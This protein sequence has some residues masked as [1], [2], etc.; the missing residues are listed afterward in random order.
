MT[1]SRFYAG[2]EWGYFRPGVRK[3]SI[4]E[5]RAS[6][7]NSD[8]IFEDYTYLFISDLQWFLLIV[9]KNNFYS[10]FLFHF[11][12]KSATYNKKLYK[13]IKT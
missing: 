10:F 6:R 2:R 8:K 3:N 9:Y 5:F 11:T 7:E 12:E 1:H 4:I 13:S